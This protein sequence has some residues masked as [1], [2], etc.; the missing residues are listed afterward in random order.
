M[1]FGAERISQDDVNA[2]KE[3]TARPETFAGRQLTSGHAKS[4]PAIPVAR[5]VRARTAFV[6]VQEVKPCFE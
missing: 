2:L 1:A 3:A 6:R 5:S 4:S